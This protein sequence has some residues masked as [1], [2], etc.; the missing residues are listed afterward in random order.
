MTDE[1]HMRQLKHENY[2]VRQD[3]CAAVHDLFVLL[4][5]K[6]YAEDSIKK[7]VEGFAQSLIKKYHWE[8]MA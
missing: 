5:P 1:E 4:A 6:C 3:L 7:R 2:E 8:D